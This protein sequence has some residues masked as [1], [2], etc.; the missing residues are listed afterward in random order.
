MALLVFE[1]LAFVREQ[2]QM[3]HLSI[4][5]T[6][7]FKNERWQ[8]IKINCINFYISESLLM[9]AVQIGLQITVSYNRQLRVNIRRLFGLTGT[10]AI[11]SG[12][13]RSRIRRNCGYALLA[14]VFIL[15]VQKHFSIRR[16]FP[17]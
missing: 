10:L 12:F 8:K 14:H 11:P 4:G 6:I 17:S 16:L 5:K 2:N 7:F 15:S 1:G 9:T 13:G 3:C